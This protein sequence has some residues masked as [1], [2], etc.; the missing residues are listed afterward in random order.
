MEER[1][2]VISNEWFDDFKIP[3]SFNRDFFCINLLGVEI[4]NPDYTKTI[5]VNKF[6]DV[7]AIKDSNL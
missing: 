7:W 6:F 2:R 4:K 3:V 5:R 1:K